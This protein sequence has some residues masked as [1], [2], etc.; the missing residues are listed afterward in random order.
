MFHK[1]I[2]VAAMPGL[3]LCVRF[4]EGVTKEYDVK[5]LL[6]KWSVFQKLANDPNLFNEVQVDTGGYGVIWGDELDLSCD[7]IFANGVPV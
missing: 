5:P 7:E 1:I 6:K 4:A 3:C 2:S